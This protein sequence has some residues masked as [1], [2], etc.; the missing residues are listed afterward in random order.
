MVFRARAFVFGILAALVAVPLAFYHA[1]VSWLARSFALLAPEPL[2][3][4]TAGYVEHIGRGSPLDSSLQNRLRHEA[5][6]HTRAA[7]RHI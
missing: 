5:R 4:A 7:P 1:G 6:M 2:A 3:F